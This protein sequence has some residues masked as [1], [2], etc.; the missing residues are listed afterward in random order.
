M[1][2]NCGR[3]AK[4]LHPATDESSCNKRF[5]CPT[6]DEQTQTIHDLKTT[7]SEVMDISVRLSTFREGTKHQTK[8]LEDWN[9]LMR[10][11]KKEGYCL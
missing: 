7:L 2:C 3:L 1:L 6:Y 10:K 9:S 5:V 11:M 4:Y 8:A